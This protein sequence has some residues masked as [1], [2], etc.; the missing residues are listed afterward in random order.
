MVKDL[1][2]GMGVEEDSPETFSMRF[3][4]TRYF[5]C[6]ADCLLLFSR[7]PHDYT[8]HQSEQKSM[9]KDV[10]C[11]MEVDVANAPFMTGYNGT[12]YYFCSDSCR[13]EFLYG[14]ERFVEKQ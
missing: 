14:P 2:C 3:H 10:V 9:A 8:N 7:V 11:G 4:G 13:Q 5:F 1:V 6:S 12:V